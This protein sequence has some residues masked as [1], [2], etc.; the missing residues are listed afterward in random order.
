[1]TNK[2]FFIPGKTS[3][4]FEIERYIQAC[5]EMLDETYETEVEVYHGLDCGDLGYI[6][7]ELSDVS[8]EIDLQESVKQSMCEQRPDPDEFMGES[9]ETGVEVTLTSVREAYIAANNCSWG[10]YVGAV[11]EELK[12]AAIEKAREKALS[13]VEG[14]KL[15]SEQAVE[16]RNKAQ[17]LYGKQVRSTHRMKEELEWCVSV[18]E[19]MQVSDSARVRM[20]RIREGLTEREEI[21]VPMADSDAEVIEAPPEA[22][23]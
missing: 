8:V 22:E 19:N 4:T 12:H 6:D 16:D 20:S 7:L 13:E 3:T 23:A 14:A 17:E 11:V 10:A 21:P 5:I 2:T 1:M 9:D 18:M 15:L